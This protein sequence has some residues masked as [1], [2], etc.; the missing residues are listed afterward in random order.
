MSVKLEL[1]D[2]SMSTLDSLTSMPREKGVD[3]QQEEEDAELSW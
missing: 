1:F 2:I 3:G